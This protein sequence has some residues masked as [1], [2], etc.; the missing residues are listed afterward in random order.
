MF[1]DD[2]YTNKQVQCISGYCNCWSFREFIL[3][4]SFNEWCLTHSS[5]ANQ[6]HLHTD[7][8]G[9]WDCWLWN[10]KHR[11]AMNISGSV[12]C[13]IYVIVWSGIYCNKVLDIRNIWLTYRINVI[14][15]E[16]NLA[17]THTIPNLW[18]Y[19]KWIAGLIHYHIPLCALLKSQIWFLRQFILD[20]L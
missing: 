7:H 10:I 5:V 12:S 11:H 20:P 16:K 8:I 6:N 14:R 4:K 13:E 1:V 18:F 15:F 3:Q 17:S 19:Q 9:Q 2:V